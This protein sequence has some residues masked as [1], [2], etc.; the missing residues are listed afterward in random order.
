MAAKDLCKHILQGAIDLKLPE[1]KDLAKTITED[2]LKQ[3]GS[4]SFAVHSAAIRC[5]AE[6]VPKISN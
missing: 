6:I 1:N 3:V 2:Y 4:M 5:L